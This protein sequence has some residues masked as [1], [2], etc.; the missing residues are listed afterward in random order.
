MFKEIPKYVDTITPIST[1][2]NAYYTPYIVETMKV[3]YHLMDL[4]EANLVVEDLKRVSE[5]KWENIFS[6]I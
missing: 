4:T 2:E 3:M 1:I 6:E 5:L